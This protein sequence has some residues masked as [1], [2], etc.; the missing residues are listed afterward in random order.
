D[1]SVELVPVQPGAA[2]IFLRDPANVNLAVLDLA[3]SSPTVAITS[4]F[5]GPVSGPQLLTWTSADLDTDVS[6][7]TY[8]LDYSAD[9]GLHWQTL[10]PRQK[11]AVMLVDF[12]ALPG[13]NGAAMI[14]VLASDGVHTGGPTTPSFS[15]RKKLPQA[16]ITS[17]A[18]GESF[19][20]GDPV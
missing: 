7:L 9:G 20:R 14:R 17:P 4:P 6:Q 18:S 11:D 15:V 1:L 13:S 19:T 12:D 8:R 3:G 10:S 2:R 16:R 5:T